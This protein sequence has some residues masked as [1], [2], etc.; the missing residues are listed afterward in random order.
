MADDVDSDDDPTILK[1]ARDGLLDGKDQRWQPATLNVGIEEIGGNGID[2]RPTQI[3]LVFDA[4]GNCVGDTV[5]R[6]VNARQTA[7]GRYTTIN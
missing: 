2:T 3:A 7:E 5:G 4:H 6:E 1:M